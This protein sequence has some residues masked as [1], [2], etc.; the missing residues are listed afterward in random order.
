M[1]QNKLVIKPADEYEYLTSE[2]NAV[3]LI[4]IH[5]VGYPHYRIRYTSQTEVILARFARKMEEYCKPAYPHLRASC[6]IA[7]HIDNDICEY[8]SKS[9]K[10]GFVSERDITWTL[11][12]SR[13]ASV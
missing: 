11:A 3:A 5:D 1:A 4:R 10:W 2:L 12:K 6:A 9:H 7:E 13:N 8:I